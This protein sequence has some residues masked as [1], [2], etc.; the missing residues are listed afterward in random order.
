MKSVKLKIS[1]LFSIEWL[2]SISHLVVPIKLGGLAV[3]VTARNSRLFG[4]VYDHAAPPGRHHLNIISTILSLD[5]ICRQSLP[6]RISSDKKMSQIFRNLASCL[7]SERPVVSLFAAL[8]A[9]SKLYH[10]FITR[11]LS[12]CS[13]GYF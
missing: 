7:N 2:Q 5:R 8:C 4:F 3:Y 12:L 11:S 9:V 10:V 13:L 6:Y 1:A